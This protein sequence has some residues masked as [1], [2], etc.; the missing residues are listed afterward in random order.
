MAHIQVNPHKSFL[1]SNTKSTTHISFMNQLIKAQLHNTLFKFLGCWFTATLQYTTQTKLIQQE[2]LGLN[3]I[4]KTKNITDKQAT[5][6]INTVIIPTLE[7]RIYNI[8]LPY[9]TCNY[10]LSQYL[11]TAKH[12]A[13]LPISAPNSTLLNNNIYGIKNI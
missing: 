6:I 13:K 9:T 1:T 4:L 3:N 11:T 12:K 8:V 5:Y 2:A 7:Y 10:I